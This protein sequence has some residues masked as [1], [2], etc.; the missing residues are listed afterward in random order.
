MNRSTKIPLL[1]SV[2]FYIACFKIYRPWCAIFIELYCSYAG[3]YLMYSEYLFSIIHKKSYIRFTWPIARQDKMLISLTYQ[4]I[5]LFPW[6]RISSCLC[7][8]V[9]RSFDCYIVKYMGCLHG[10]LSWHH[11]IF[12]LF[13]RTP[14]LTS[15][16]MT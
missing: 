11:F 9:W 16:L 1:N 3:Y 12:M 5:S 13:W 14:A 2:R 10:L 8:N 6:C 7:D 15:L 4:H